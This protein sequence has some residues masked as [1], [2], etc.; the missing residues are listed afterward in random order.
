MELTDKR[1]KLT[2]HRIEV[3][4]SLGVFTVEDLLTYY[5]IRYE[6]LNVRPYDDWRI[7][8]R[9]SFEGEVVSRVNS[10]RYAGK[11]TVSRFDVLAFGTYLHVTVFNRPWTNRLAMNQIITITGVYKGKGQVTATGYTEKPL[12]EVPA[13]TPVYSTKAGIPQRTIRECIRKTMDNC[14]DIPDVVPQ[15][16]IMRYRLLHRQDALNR[17]H[18]P[19]SQEDVTSALRT[20][21]YEEFLKFFT[22]VKL[23]SLSMLNENAKEPKR[24]DKAKV[25]EL[26]GSLSYA[27]TADQQRTID[28]IVSDMSSGRAMYRLVQGDVGCGK[29]LVAEAALFAAWTAGYQSALLAPT[30]ILAVQHY[31]AV[32]ALLMPYGIHVRLLHSGLKSSVRQEILEDLASG[33]TDVLIGTHSILQDDVAFRKLGLVI[34][35]EQQRFGVEQRRKLRDKGTQVDFLLMSAT[36]IPRTLAGTIYGDMDIS[37]I[38]T[39]PPGRMPVITKLIEENSFRSVLSEVNELIDSGQQL[40][41][42]CAA[43]EDSPDYDARNVVDVGNALSKLFAGRAAVGILHGQMNSAL[44]QSVMND[45]QDNRIQVL[46]STTVVEVGV[47]VVNA[48]GMIIYDADRFGMSQIHQLR[49]RVQ[50]GSTQGRCWLLTDTDDEGALERLRILASTTDGFRIAYEDL[51][52]RGPGDILG[53]RQSGLPGITLGNLVEDTGIINTARRDASD[54][55]EHRDDPAYRTLLELVMAENSRNAAYID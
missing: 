49:G 3:L 29:T 40:Y 10:W 24:I 34:A 38:E 4:H 37:T 30:E 5:P 36:P 28:E 43:L 25:D 32:S 16:L 19:S 6:T 7:N 42:V 23:S 51:R 33:R 54:I 8:D 31:M 53:T 52:L 21:K 27:P 15:E 55:V 18:F 13:V 26:L 17:I 14:P 44:K 1:L 2:K 12:A 35:D 39:M 50:R 22:A 47:N 41:V 9:V 45:F 20:L 11:K 48:T 46:V